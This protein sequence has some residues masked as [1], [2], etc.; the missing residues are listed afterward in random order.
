MNFFKV[1]FYKPI[2]NLLMAIYIF[3]PLHDLGLSIIFLTIIIRLILYPLSKK[4]LISQK[5][6]AEISPKIKEI[7]QKYK[8]KEE[9]AQKMIEFYKNA[10]INPFS[11]VLLLILQLPIFIG[12]YQVCTKG[13]NPSA[14]SD[15]YSFLP[16]NINLNLVAFGFL[17]LA[18]PNLILAILVGVLQFFYS[19]SNLPKKTVKKKT[20]DF[21]DLLQKEM[22]FLGPLFIFFILL[23]LP[24]ALSL[25]FLVSTLWSFFENY[26]LKK[27]KKILS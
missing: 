9:Q 8:N 13:I 2:F 10:K 27:S 1:I 24:S 12:L 19:K 22:V 25:Y 7:Q 16:N 15:L 17:N 26:L 6:L 20:S 3:F 21:S 4:A 23:K 14:L 18:K 5:A 11:G